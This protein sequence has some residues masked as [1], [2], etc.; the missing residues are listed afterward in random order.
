M[1]QEIVK[2]INHLQAE[3]ASWK[4]TLKETQL[5]EDYASDKEDIE[6]EIE[7]LSTEISN[8]SSQL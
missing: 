7:N 8:L 6:K 1:N 4:V 5:N 3:R 2:Q